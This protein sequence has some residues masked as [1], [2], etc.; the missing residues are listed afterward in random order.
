MAALETPT[1][2]DSDHPIR[3]VALVGRSD[4]NC[5]SVGLRSEGGLSDGLS[6]GRFVSHTGTVASGVSI[7]L[8]RNENINEIWPNR[9]F[10]ILNALFVPPSSHSA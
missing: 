8:L 5:R 9:V 7:M 2:T 1:Q 6:D 4:E 3:P 10:G